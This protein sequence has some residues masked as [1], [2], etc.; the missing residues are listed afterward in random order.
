[1]VTAQIVFDHYNRAKKSSEERPL[2]VRVTVNRHSYYINTGV[3]VCARQWSFDK[4]INHPQ[5][6]ALNNRLSVILEKVNF[7]VNEML[8]SGRTLDIAEVKRF[9]WGLSKDETF[10][11]WIQSEIDAMD[12]AEGTKK[13]Y[14][15][16]LNRLREYGNLQAWQDLTVENIYK[17]DAWI[18]KL[19]GRTGKITT[20][21]IYNYH[22]CLKV[23]LG[24][25]ERSGLLQS[26]PYH[27]LRGE[28][29]RG[30]SES[31]E[32]LTE[33]EIQ[34]IIN[35]AP[36]PDTW[37][38]RAKDLFVFQIYTGLS[39]ADTQAFDIK[40]YKE[41]NGKLRKVGT[42]VKTGQPY[43]SQLL[44]PAIAILEKYGMTVPKLTNQV[45][46]RE[47]KAVGIAAGITTPLHSHLARHT[48][49]TYMLRHGASIENVSKMLGHSTIKHTQ[50]YA[51]VLA[52]SV[53][54]EFEKIEKELR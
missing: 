9:V 41:I 30:E 28:F 27:R 12:F 6:N 7:R 29:G 5:S 53:F 16:V 23:L 36:A 48:F 4:I 26:N 11:E 51:K 32:Y 3:R 50:R 10:L 35:F 37:M 1:M 8:S 18:R 47:L 43:I 34:K 49:A 13:H 38:E 52:E 33:S 24:R 21:S 39:Y 44:P 15:S 40:G 22:K 14:L 17:L 19:K 42:R 45:Y 20:A 54:N 31:T 46:N 25:A 2:E